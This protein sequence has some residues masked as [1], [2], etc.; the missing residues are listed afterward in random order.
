MPEFWEAEGLITG[1]RS[2][3]CYV[4]GLMVLVAGVA[5]I[6]AFS[7]IWFL[8]HA[9]MNEQRERLVEQARGEARLLEAI[10]RDE[11]REGQSAA[12]AAAAAL[13]QVD[14]ALSTYEPAAATGDVQIG[15]REGD[16]VVFLV[17]HH[18][19]DELPAPLPVGG[20]KAAP[21]Q[22]AL[23]GQTGTMI[24]PDY[25]GVSVLAAYEP[26]AG[27]GYGV[28]AK[29]DL[30]EV[31]APFR[32][33]AW[34]ALGPTF[35]AILV[36]GGLLLVLNRPLLRRTREAELRYDELVHAMGEGFAVLDEE[37]RFTHVNGRLCQIF[38]RERSELLG[39]YAGDFHAPEDRNRLVELWE[40]RRRGEGSAQEFLVVRPDGERRNV[41]I[42]GQPRYDRGVFAGSL[43]VATDVTD[44]RRASE[45]LQRQKDLAR[46]YFDVAGVILVV[47]DSEGRIEL[48]NRHGASVLGYQDASELV[49]HDWFSACLPA[50]GRDEVR[51]VFARIM[52]GDL[53]P[54]ERFENEILRWD[55]ERR[56]I[57]W[58]NAVLHDAEGRICGTLSSGEDITE[59][60]RQSE[61]MA[62]LNAILRAI[63]NVNQVIT[64]EKDRGHLLDAGC[65]E[66]VATGVIPHAW[67]VQLD[68][69]GSAVRVVEA[70]IG[71]A[72]DVVRGAVRG[73][74]LPRCCREALATGNPSILASPG[75][76]CAECPARTAHSGTTALAVPMRHED[77]TYGVLVAAIPLS[78]AADPEEVSLL[79]EV[80]GDLA[81]ALHS[82]DESDARRAAE[83]SL[84]E[85]EEQYRS[86]F[87]NAV[88]GV[89]FTTPAGEIVAANP[90]LVAM[91]GYESFEELA[92]RNLDDDS[93]NPDYLRSAFKE[94]LE[95]DGRVVGLESAWARKDG[96]TVY[97][98]ENAKAV[99]SGDGR[100]LFYEGTVEDITARHH[101]EEGRR[102]IE[103]QLRQA[104]KLESIGTLASGIAHEI[105]NPLTGII[106]YAQLIADRSGDEALREFAQGI[107]NEGNRVAAIVRNLLAFS[108]QQKESHSPARIGDIASATLSLIGA[109][110]RKDGIEVV[111]DVPDG[112]PTVKCRSQQIQ[113][114]LMNL[115]T[116]ARDA[117]N[118]RYTGF[119]EDKTIHIVASRVS[120]D[121]RAWIRLSVEDGGIGMPPE[122]LD[123]VFDPFF[124][125]KPRDQ[126]TGLGLSI[127]YG[128]VRDHHGTLTAESEPGRWTR[129]TMDLPIDNGGTI[130]ES[131]SGPAEA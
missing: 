20:S 46:G 119:D 93:F 74:A 21:M 41:R 92:A 120:H 26:V 107:V 80:A 6:V 39:R 35:G 49:G 1:A 12:D 124:T 3:R 131:S 129:F 78:W 85:S 114:V 37:A 105:N 65:R 55:G 70:G 42:S 95:R 45:D 121:G 48:I 69:D 115:L 103:I 50:D 58:H 64:R 30:T 2:R 88:L 7:A 44:L 59:L 111:S 76:E 25:R 4:V 62:H 82:V 130:T 15:R 94:R 54:V 101:A 29:V 67:I 128:I 27:L 99:R 72:F 60:R 40:H 8:E 127:S 10:A 9:A 68:A 96:S 91:L 24:G 97:V 112:L 61:R 33:A 108:R 16:Q 116:N 84:H 123:R 22:R 81:F 110:L 14:D 66:L 86:L 102:Q 75:A 125:T 52:A 31:R 83:A 28:V 38:G 5:G 32:L 122:V 57:L 53:A 11:L 90:A 77:R 71:A 117:L 18:T 73:G 13:A 109:S 63:R 36:G 104:Q 87:E 98:R 89:Y 79:V 43:A 17:H 113:Q 56:L 23:S 47:L 19:T 118:A 100:V 126:G 34:L 51:R 106:N